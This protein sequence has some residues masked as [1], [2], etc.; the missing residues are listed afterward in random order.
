MG[1][2][3]PQRLRDHGSSQGAVGADGERMLFGRE[4]A[5]RLLAGTTLQRRAWL[6]PSIGSPW[7]FAR[8]GRSAGALPLEGKLILKIHP[9]PGRFFTSIVPPLSA[10]AR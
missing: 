10:I 1:P 8:T 6:I 4:K 2:K 9:R 7:P 5:G 3:C